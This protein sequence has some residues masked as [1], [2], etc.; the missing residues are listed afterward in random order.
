MKRKYELDAAHKVIC[1]CGYYNNPAK[2]RRVGNSKY[3]KCFRCG[4][5]LKSKKDEFKDN[6]VALL[7]GESK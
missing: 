3:C 4:R 5:D 1:V 6:L 7:K 2:L